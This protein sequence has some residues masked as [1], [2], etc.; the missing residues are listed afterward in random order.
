MFLCLN[1]NK[2]SLLDQ[3][4]YYILF[5]A[6]FII[7]ETLFMPPVSESIP[8]P[9]YQRFLDAISV[10][11]LPISGSELHGVMCGYLSTGSIDQGNLYLRALIAKPANEAERL[12]MLTLFETY[13]ASQQQIEGFGLEFELLLPDDDESL[14]H[15]AQTFSEWCDGFLQGLRMSGVDYNQLEDDAVQDAIAHIG[16]FADLDYQSLEFG[17]ADEQSLMEITEYTR[18]AVLHIHSDLQVHRLNER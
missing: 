9:S 17:E 18:M 5:K 10:L 7:I 11:N 2:F 15:R 3:I 14:L 4:G 16:D 8:L 6:C 13:A 12:A 1:G